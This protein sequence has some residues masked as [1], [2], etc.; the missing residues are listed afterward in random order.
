MIVFLETCAKKMQIFLMS[1]LPLALDVLTL[2]KL[3]IISSRKHR[4]P[5]LLLYH[6]KKLIL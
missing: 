1:L 6:G 2:T 3:S 4:H 5:K